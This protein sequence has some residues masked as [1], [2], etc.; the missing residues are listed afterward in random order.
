MIKIEFKNKNYVIVEKEDLVDNDM[1]L[2]VDYEKLDNLSDIII[3]NYNNEFKILKGNKDHTINE[4]I[5]LYERK[6]KLN[7]LKS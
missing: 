5:K 4:V 2:F 1:G 7:K 6:R 3:L